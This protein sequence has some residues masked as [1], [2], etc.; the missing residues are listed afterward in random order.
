MGLLVD[1][2][3]R[4]L[5]A[6]GEMVIEP[7][8]PH[9]VRELHPESGDGASESG[10]AAAYR[11]VSY[12]LSS[13]G[14]DLRVSDEIYVYDADFAREIDVKAFDARALTRLPVHEE[15]GRGRFVVFPARATGLARAYERLRIPRDLL[16]TCTGKSTYARA[17]LMVTITPIEPEWEG[18]L[19]FHLHNTLPLP[20]RVYVEEGIAQL[21]F[22]RTDALCAASY[23][24]KGGK[25]QAQG[26]GV[27][28]ARV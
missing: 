5:V 23:E 15:A 13:A 27:T 22:N 2:Q 7:F 10:A 20:V 18:Y 14:Y 9:P 12:G 19:S 16:V 4:D 17:G 3:I 8:T 24:D 25:Y 21:L 26:K 1:W 28:T 11:V 6:A